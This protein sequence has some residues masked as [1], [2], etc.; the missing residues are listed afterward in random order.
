MRMSKV[1]PMGC[2]LALLSSVSAAGS[3]PWTVLDN[4]TPA[5]KGGPHIL[6]IYDMEGLSGQDDP[7]TWM[8]EYPTYAR[9]QQL[10]TDDVNAVFVGLFS[11]GAQA[12]S[13]IDGH[14]GGN[15]Q[16]D[17]LAERVDPRAKLLRGKIDGYRD[18]ARTGE[19]DG[20][21]AVAMHAKSGSGGFSAHT[22]TLGIEI[23]VNGRSVNETELLAMG[24]GEAGIPV[25]F[26]S[27][28]DH[29]GAELKSMPWLEYV[30]VKEAIGV[31][32]AKLYPIAQVHARMTSAAKRAVEK[33]P[34]AKVVKAI[35]PVK[36][37]VRAFPPA[38]LSWLA[39]MP[40]VQYRDQAVSFSAP[41]FQAAYRGMQPIGVAAYQA[42]FKTTQAALEAHPDAKKIEF[43][44]VEDLM[45]VW[46]ETETARHQN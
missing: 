16:D 32:S 19:F 6:L 20:V 41:D 8:S 35:T 15:L 13:I 22:W 24:Y 33:L 23:A 45:R 11:G 46:R 34:T 21:A 38:D 18:L 17:I 9:G 7:T 27:G 25:I 2:M 3:D 43:R 4:E 36:M 14:G 30:V 39:D 31:A 10:L 37:T 5:R 28:D 44:A 12:V 40:G 29:L 1:V 26:A 42:F